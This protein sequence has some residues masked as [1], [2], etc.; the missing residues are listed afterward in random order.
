[1]GEFNFEVGPVLEDVAA[2]RDE[3]AVMPLNVCT[4]SIE[5]QLEQ[6]IGV[7]EGIG[8]AD[9]GHGGERHVCRI[10]D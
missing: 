8:D 6:P 1:M 5:L 2:P 3:T 10:P 4:K 7:I 9:D